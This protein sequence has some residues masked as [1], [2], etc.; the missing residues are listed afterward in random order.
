MNHTGILLRHIVDTSL[1]K[2]TEDIIPA[3]GFA[4]DENC[5]ASLGEE[6]GQPL[7]YVSTYAV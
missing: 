4:I 5:L 1:Q 2:T 3:G 6:A 7:Q